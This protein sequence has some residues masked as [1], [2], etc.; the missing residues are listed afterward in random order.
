MS[1]LIT[2][3][4]KHEAKFSQKG[5]LNIGIVEYTDM[6]G[7]LT[8]VNCDCCMKKYFSVFQLIGEPI[9]NRENF[10][11]YRILLCPKC[12]K[13]D[14]WNVLHQELKNLFTTRKAQPILDDCMMSDISNIII[15]YLPI[16]NSLSFTLKKIRNEIQ[17]ENNQATHNNLSYPSESYC[18]ILTRRILCR[19]L[20]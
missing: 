9:N 20:F 13:K 6:D 16:E 4:K 8:P 7:D 2:I 18:D 14:L 1:W 12:L 5:K 17:F 10:S 11:F 3:H 15:N 19:R